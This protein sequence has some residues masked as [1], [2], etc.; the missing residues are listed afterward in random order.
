[1]LQTNYRTDK[2]IISFFSISQHLDFCSYSVR[3]TSGIIDEMIPF[4]VLNH[5]IWCST[6]AHDKGAALY[7]DWD[8]PID[9]EGKHEF[10]RSIS[11]LR[12][13]FFLSH[14]TQ[15]A[16][17]ER[18]AIP[19][20]GVSVVACM[21][22]RRRLRRLW[23]WCGTNNNNNNDWSVVSSQYLPWHAFVCAFVCVALV[24]QALIYRWNTEIVKWKLW[25]WNC[26]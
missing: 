16:V 24:H 4:V 5:T 23:H 17:C 2:F 15:L 25:Y 3:R 8:A 11:P 14:C 10:V 9:W 6:H 26:K 22:S 13:R 7:G 18:H 21:W 19:M 20:Y 12:V 1:M